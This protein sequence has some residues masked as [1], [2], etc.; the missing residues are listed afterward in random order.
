[1]VLVLFILLILPTFSYAQELCGANNYDNVTLED[2]DTTYSVVHDEYIIQFTGYYHRE[3]RHGFIQACLRGAVGW[4]IITRHN[5]AYG[6]PSDFDLVHLTEDK[7]TSVQRL[8]RHPLIHKVKANMMVHRQLRS[9]DPRYYDT[10]FN[11]RQSLTSTNTNSF[12]ES[13]KFKSRSL[14]RNVPR[15]ITSALEAETLWRL[16]YSGQGVRV[17]VFDTGLAEDHPH[18][19]RGRVKD[20]TN[21]TEEKSKNDGLGH[22]TFVAG[23]I[24]S[25][26]E[27]LGFAPDA[28]LYI[29]RVFTNN[30]VSYTSWFLDAFN[31]AIMKKIHVLNLSIGGPDFMDH[32]FVDK[33]HLPNSNHWPN[34]PQT[35]PPYP[36]QPK[37]F[38]P[39]PRLARSPQTTTWPTLPSPL[40]PT[41]PP[42]TLVPGLPSLSDPT[43]P[44]FPP[45]LP[46]LPLP[47]GLPSPSWSAPTP[48]SHH[49]ASH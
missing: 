13:V 30:Q 22:G 45:T 36:P 18:F 2:I 28:D 47:R 33:V 9:L 21:W 11:S 8:S 32:P 46:A 3:A 35:L 23:I 6:Y 17:A 48:L 20:R 42:L 39:L 44:L 41:R 25:Y 19:K 1:M 15:Q 12:W 24:G 49:S 27:C 10:E 38:C 37:I 43:R 40:P 34:N 16:G 14:K 31:Y 26:K 7:D 5:P 29:F 4:D